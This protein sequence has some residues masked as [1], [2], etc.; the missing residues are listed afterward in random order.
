M[1]REENDQEENTVEVINISSDIVRFELEKT[2]YRLA[3][4]ERMRVHKS[5]GLPRQLQDGRDPVPSTVELL[6]NKKVLPISDKRARGVVASL[7]ATGQ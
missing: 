3:P 5:Y 4:K 1:A 2:R 7:E 6:T